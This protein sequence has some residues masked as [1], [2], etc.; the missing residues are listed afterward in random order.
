MTL[1]KI[2]ISDTVLIA[3]IGLVTPVLALWL[4]FRLD[5]IEKQNISMER[6]IDGRMDELLRLARLEGNV[7]GKIAGKAEEKAEQVTSNTSQTTITPLKSET[8]IE[9]KIEGVIK[10]K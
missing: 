9:G 5:K 8:K 7:E 10:P 2:I 1:L 4:K 3:L 6:R